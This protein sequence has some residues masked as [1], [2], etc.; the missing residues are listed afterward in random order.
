MKPLFATRCELHAVI[1]PSGCG[2]E[3][4]RFDC[5]SG[6]GSR[7]WSR[8]FGKIAVANLEADNG[9]GQN[10]QKRAR[11]PTSLLGVSNGARPTSLVTFDVYPHNTDKHICLELAEPIAGLLNYLGL[12]ADDSRF[13]MTS[14]SPS[15]L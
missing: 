12:T 14:P 8:A 7:G 1:Q 15:C 4:P 3:S 9:G 10:G 6:C 2:R 11:A 13:A 5:R